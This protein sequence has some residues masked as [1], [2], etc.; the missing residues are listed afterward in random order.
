MVKIEAKN[1]E[2]CIWEKVACLYLMVKANL[3]SDNQI[4]GCDDHKKI[5][6]KENEETAIHIIIYSYNTSVKVQ[7]T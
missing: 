1:L 7:L 5:S 4:F 6:Q 3:R 2:I